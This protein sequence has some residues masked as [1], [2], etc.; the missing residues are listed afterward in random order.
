MIWGSEVTTLW[1]AMA[2]GPEW[3]V[4]VQTYTAQTPR[5]SLSERQLLVQVQQV[6]NHRSA[7][8]EG[9][10]GTVEGDAEEEL[11][12]LLTDVGSYETE[13]DNGE[14]MFGGD[15]HRAVREQLDEGPM[16]QEQEGRRTKDSPPYAQYSQNAIADPTSIGEYRD[17]RGP[18]SVVSGV[19]SRGLPMLCV[20][21]VWPLG[22]DREP[23]TCVVWRGHRGPAGL[24]RCTSSCA[25]FAAGRP[26]PWLPPRG[27]G[28]SFRWRSQTRDGDGRR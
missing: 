3:M 22:G 24:P 21:V 28:G 5:A 13:N 27:R 6:A 2:E 15:I 16:P 14:G 7:H 10:A 25:P 11:A 23:P 18:L 20:A 4:C 8:D 1:W 26:V 19:S 9:I 17:Y 12:C